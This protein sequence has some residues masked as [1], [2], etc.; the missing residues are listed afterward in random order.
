MLSLVA[1]ILYDTG[2]CFH[3]HFLSSEVFLA[4]YGAGH[5][6]E[7]LSST[8]ATHSPKEVPRAMRSCSSSR[9]P[10]QRASSART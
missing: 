10:E 4:T 5:H 1:Y 3:V 8:S 7:I 2:A 6:S 9:T